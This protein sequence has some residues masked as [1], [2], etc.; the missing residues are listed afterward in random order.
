MADIRRDDDG[1]DVSDY[2]RWFGD[3]LRY[4]GALRHMF[5]GKAAIAHAADMGD[6]GAGNREGIERLF[7]EILGNAGERAF[8]GHEFAVVAVKHRAPRIRMTIARSAA[9][10]GEPNSLR[11]FN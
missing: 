1:I 7:I 5:C 3:H 8:A 10:H 4:E 6:L 2:I 9:N 11:V